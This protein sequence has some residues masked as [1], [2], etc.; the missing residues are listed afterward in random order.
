MRK[1]KV[2]MG[3]CPLWTSQNSESHPRDVGIQASGRII[4]F[5]YPHSR[6]L[7]LFSVQRPPS[8]QRVVMLGTGCTLRLVVDLT[9][10]LEP[11]PQKLA[12]D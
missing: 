4:D 3:P 11:C 12:Q 7:P 8:R 2:M 5:N 10:L 6:S 9:R 1:S